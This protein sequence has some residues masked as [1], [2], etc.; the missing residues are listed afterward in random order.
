M[1]MLCVRKVKRRR[2]VLYSHTFACRVLSSPRRL[3]IPSYIF[4]L[5]RAIFKHSLRIGL[6]VAHLLSFLLVN[7]V[8]IFLLCWSIF[9]QGIG[10]WF[11]SSFLFVFEVLIYF[12]G[13][14][15]DFWIVIHCYSKNFFH[16]L[17]RYCFS[18]T[19]FKVF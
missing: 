13:G 1:N 7:Y 2:K 17:V 11:H 5:W 15:H 12:L 3:K 4:C 9:F 6:P 19:T 14:P 16:L 8:L 18:L 10:F